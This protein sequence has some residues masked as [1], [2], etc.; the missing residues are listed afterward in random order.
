MLKLPFTGGPVGVAFDSFGNSYV[1]EDSGSIDILKT[2]NTTII[3]IA[4]TQTTNYGL[5]FDPNNTLYVATDE[6][7]YLSK[8]SDYNAFST[9]IKSTDQLIGSTDP[10]DP[11][12]SDYNVIGAISNVTSD[13]SGNIFATTRNFISLSQLIKLNYNSVTQSYTA[14]KLYGLPTVQSGTPNFSAGVTVDGNGKIYFA[15]SG[16]DDVFTAE[17][18]PSSPTGYNVRSLLHLNDRKLLVSTSVNGITVDDQNIPYMIDAGAK[19]VLKVIP[20]QINLTQ[21]TANG[22]VFTLDK[23]TTFTAVNGV[24]DSVIVLNGNSLYIN[25]ANSPDSPNLPTS[26]FN[27]DL[28]GSAGG[29]AI[30]TGQGIWALQGNLTAPIEIQAGTVTVMNGSIMKPITVDNNSTLIVGS[31]NRSF[32]DITN[33]GTVIFDTPTPIAYDHIISGSG[34]VQK[35]GVGTLITTQNNIYTGGTS[36]NNGTYQLMGNTVPGNLNVENGAYLTGSGLVNQT[37]SGSGTVSPGTANNFG[38]I[39]THD[40]APTSGSILNIAINFDPISASEVNNS[41]LN[42]VGNADLSQTQLK[43]SPTPGNYPDAS[44]FVFLNSEGPITTQ[45]VSAPPIIGPYTANY[46]Y[47]NNNVTLKLN[48]LTLTGTTSNEQRVADYLNESKMDS[49][50][51]IVRQAL[52]YLDA[53]SPHDVDNALDSISAESNLDYG[54]QTMVSSTVANSITGVRMEALRNSA[55]GRSSAA[56]TAFNFRIYAA[57]Y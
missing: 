37:L 55:S 6:G 16:R 45:F 30:K 36:I 12:N 22:S 25:L 50:L 43:I 3:Q 28:D 32:S 34:T 5:T 17:A 9:I 57:K 10:S 31:A 44:Q 4:D 52:A 2:N 53:Q 7:I 26:T 40:Y 33:N 13:K 49:D 24:A 51:W 8:P 23:D 42:V 41:V 48:L 21:N 29:T 19:Q 20:D 54:L 47:N 11:S 56:P 14:S 1:A 46:N 27:G 38:T 35:N 15:L 18:D 39:K